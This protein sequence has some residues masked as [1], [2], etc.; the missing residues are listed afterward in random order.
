VPI[1]L[2]QRRGQRPANVTIRGIGAASLALRPQVRLLAGRLPKPGSGEIAAGASIARRFRGA[3][4]GEQLRFAQRDWL[5]VGILEAGGS[6]FDS[7]IWGRRQLMAF[8]RSIYLG[9]AGLRDLSRFEELKAPRRATRASSSRPSAS[10]FY[11]DQSEMMAKFL[12]SSARCWRRS[13]RSA[14]SSAR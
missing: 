11:A 5:V 4:L 9:A 3:G 13:S 12:R 6:A 10:R 7:E 8:R 14:R 1:S 2:L